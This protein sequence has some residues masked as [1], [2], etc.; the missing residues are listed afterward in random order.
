MI[1]NDG[2]YKLSD[3]VETDITSPKNFELSQNYP[4]PFNPSTKINYSLPYDS[5]VTLEIYNVLGA[6]VGQ[7]VNQEQS[8]GFYS[9]DF[10]S[11]S[12]GKGISSG[13]YLYKIT[14]V[15]KATGNNFSAIKKMM[16]LK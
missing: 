16:L 14:T 6:R 5:R 13:V 8:A 2:S 9:V 11:S 12:L 1:D 10:N 3:I 15:D 4:N 7:L